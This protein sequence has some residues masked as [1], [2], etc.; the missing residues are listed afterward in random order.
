M[1]IEQL[2]E[3]GMISRSEY[4]SACGPPPA[5]E[6]VPLQG[7]YGFD[8][9]VMDG[10]PS[11]LSLFGRAYRPLRD[12]ANLAARRIAIY[13]NFGRFKVFRAGYFTESTDIAL[14][15]PSGEGEFEAQVWVPRGPKV[16]LYGDLLSSDGGYDS[17]ELYTSHRASTKAGA[18]AAAR[19]TA[20]K[21]GIRS[22][23]VIDAAYWNRPFRLVDDGP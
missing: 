13:A 8:V 7:E 5:L 18:M 19:R 12:S 23:T 11:E 4:P 21:E 10:D 15:E 16:R 6:R 14:V 1:T 3:A 22:F 9:Y 17:L 2:H 20:L